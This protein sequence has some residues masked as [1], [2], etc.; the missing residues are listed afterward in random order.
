VIGLDIEAEMVDRTA[1]RA[2][3]PGLDQVQTRQ[4][5]VTETGPWGERQRERRGLPLLRRVLP[6]QPQAS[7][8]R[9]AH[10]VATRR[11]TSATVRRA[12]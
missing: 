6:R 4:I 5:D 9:S 3:D 12:Q 11:L 2:R 1:R 10:L 8:L 7:R